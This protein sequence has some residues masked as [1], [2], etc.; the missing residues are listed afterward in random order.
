VD[1]G[2]ARA[3]LV[4]A[5]AA[6]LSGCY[7]GH[8]VR[9]QLQML[10]AREPIAEVLADPQTDPELRRRLQ[11]ALDARS[12]A[13]R[14][15]GLP[16]NDSYTTYAD[17]GRPYAVWNVFATPALS[18]QPR[19]WCHLFVGCLAYQGYYDRARA[20]RTAA[21]LRE[22]GLDVFV[23]GIPTYSTLGWFDDPL[24]STMRGGED[25]IAGM[26]FHELAHQVTFAAGDTAFNESFAT[27]VEE[28]GLRRY[29]KDAPELAREARR[30]QRWEA[31]YRSLM[32]AAR[33]RLA[34]TYDS[35]ATDEQKAA[36]KHEVFERLRK[37]YV[38]LRRAWRAD[39]REDTWLTEPNNAQLLPFGLYHAWVPAFAVLFQKHGGDWRAFYA[40]ADELAGLDAKTRHARLEALSPQ[41]APPDQPSEEEAAEEEAAEEPAEEPE[42]PT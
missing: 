29:L 3:A 41:V 36:R 9:G 20:D 24:L 5:L 21:E 11:R 4:A 34:E 35:E 10:T 22:A 14:A 19:Q 40:A 28:E 16:R 23:A 42:G 30:R 15:L 31:G 27:F 25:E 7:Y 18:L 39:W 12:F 8:L 17:L 33:K 32:F 1:A 2:L 6:L 26:I 13:T 38:K 37:D